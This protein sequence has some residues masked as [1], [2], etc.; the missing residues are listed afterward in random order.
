M[1]I[2]LLRV[3]LF[4]PNCNSL[5]AKRS[6]VKKHVNYLRR[7]YNVGVAEVDNNDRWRTCTL[8][9]VTVYSLRDAVEKTFYTIINDLEKTSDI[10]LSHYEIELL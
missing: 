4:I 1:I 5:K 6:I 3:N 9:I 8:A 2:G 7:H 10:Q